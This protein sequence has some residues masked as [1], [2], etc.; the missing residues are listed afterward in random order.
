[1]GK[2]EVKKSYAVM[3][4]EAVV[5]LN[6]RKGCSQPALEGYIL[7]HNKKLD[8]KRH[9]LR[10]AI[11]RGLLSG[12]FLVHH[13]HKNSIKLPPKSARKPAKKPAKKKPAKK[14]TTKKKTKKRTTKKT[15]KRT[16]KKTTKK[17]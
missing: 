10:N 7:S 4:T 6:S 14:R 13:N 5:G 8:F 12:A 15:K 1:M 9:L 16:T 11:K 2:K 3:I 17:K